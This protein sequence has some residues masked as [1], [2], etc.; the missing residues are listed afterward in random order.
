MSNDTDATSIARRA[1]QLL[2]RGNIENAL[3]EF[4]RAIL[5]EPT[6][7]LALQGIAEALGAAGR[8]EEAL[9]YAEQAVAACP[10]SSEC[11][12]ALGRVLRDLQRH[13]EAAVAFQRAIRR[14]PDWSEPHVHLAEVYREQERLWEAEEEFRRAVNIDPQD[15]SAWEGLGFCR[16]FAG[17][18]EIAKNAYR[19]S[20]EVGADW[21]RPWWL[22]AR[23]LLFLDRVGEARECLDDPKAKPVPDE[24]RAALLAAQGSG[25]E[26]LLL[27]DLARRNDG[28]A[29]DPVSL[30]MA[31]QSL[32]Q[33]QTA[34]RYYE[35]GAEKG[36]R[37]AVER[38]KDLPPKS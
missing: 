3:K 20:M 28:A 4:H 13:D 17:D 15:A 31:Y 33:I 32:G 18:Y 21:G 23:L 36:E 29:L 19:R 24:L 37:L 11:Y 25:D 16:E 30:G 2:Q 26:A 1:W 6:N 38:L 8:Y 7:G 35:A 5:A 10:E 14:N 34:R 12:D 22:L 9:P 27:I